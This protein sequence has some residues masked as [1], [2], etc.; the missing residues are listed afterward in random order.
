MTYRQLLKKIDKSPTLQFESKSVR[1]YGQTAASLLYWQTSP[2]V[3]AKERRES[4]IQIK[5]AKDWKLV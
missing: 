5:K 4:R 2:E 3:S 1:M